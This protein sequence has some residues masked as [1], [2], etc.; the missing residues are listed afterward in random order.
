MIKVVKNL[1][2]Y[3]FWQWRLPSI[4]VRGLSESAVG[5]GLSDRS[6]LVGTVCVFS[7]VASYSSLSLSSSVSSSSAWWSSHRI[8]CSWPRL[9]AHFWKKTHSIWK[10]YII[11]Y[12]ITNQDSVDRQYTDY[13]C[14]SGIKGVVKHIL[15]YWPNGTQVGQRKSMHNK[16]HHFFKGNENSLPFSDLENINR[17]LNI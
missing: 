11:L 17:L 15:V 9:L 13:V 7:T 1:L 14:T 12:A 5:A 8:S 16:L 2:G 6:I 10:I 4:L 3:N